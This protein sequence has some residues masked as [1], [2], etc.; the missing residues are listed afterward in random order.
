MMTGTEDGGIIPT[1]ARAFFFTKG[2]WS[3]NKR[4]RLASEQGVELDLRHHRRDKM[5]GRDIVAQLQHGS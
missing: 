3:T 5:D 2:M 1:Y 4:R